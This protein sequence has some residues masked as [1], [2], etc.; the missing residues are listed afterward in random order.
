MVAG[1]GAYTSPEQAQSLQDVTRRALR[2]MDATLAVLPDT[3]ADAIAPTIAT[4]VVP[5]LRRAILTLHEALEAAG[6]PV[7]PGAYPAG[8]RFLNAAVATGEAMEAAV[9][10]QIPAALATELR[11]AE[12]ELAEQ[13]T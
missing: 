10:D 5:E 3:G 12:A 1:A 13:Q 6:R 2:V 8:I 11:V 4:S 9:D 7:P